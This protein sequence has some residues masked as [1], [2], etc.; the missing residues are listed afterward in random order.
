MVDKHTFQMYG[1][2]FCEQEWLTY[3]KD[4]R[5][6]KHII[7]KANLICQNI[8]LFDDPLDMECCYIPHYFKDI[9]WVFT[10]NGDDEW[11]FMLNRQ[12]FMVELSQAFLLTKEE[13]YIQKWKELAFDWIKKK[14]SRTKQIRRH[15]G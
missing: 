14:V 3:V 1:N 10:P 5:R 12:G 2:L 9:D 15:G 4:T 8:F 7:Y 11:V 13:K 6:A